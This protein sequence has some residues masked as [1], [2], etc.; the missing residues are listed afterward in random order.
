MLSV[1]IQIVVVAAMALCVLR[2]V[3]LLSRGKL[4]YKLGIGWIGVFCS[5]AGLVLAP[6]LLIRAARLLGIAAPVNMLFFFGFLFCAAIL[7]A[8]SRRTANL[9]AQVRRIAQELA[10]LRKEAE[11]TAPHPPPPA[12]GPPAAR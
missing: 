5:I 2:A 3:W 4:D 9:L 1:R 8:L 11:K 10:I 12:G 7:F 6:G